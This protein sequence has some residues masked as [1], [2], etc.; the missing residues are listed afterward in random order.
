MAIQKFTWGLT[1]TMKPPPMPMPVTSTQY[2]IIR[3]P[4]SNQLCYYKYGYQFQNIGHNDLS[5]AA[6]LHW[7]QPYMCM[8]SCLYDQPCVL[9]S[10]V[11]SQCHKIN[12]L[13]L[14]RLCDI[15]C[16]ISQNLW[17]VHDRHTHRWWHVCAQVWF[18]PNPNQPFMHNIQCSFM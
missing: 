18:G 1:V 5:F 2:W 16:K 6:L 4:D 14:N 3:T 17:F 7:V 9:R 13:G 12:N 11:H 15:A 8:I 10:S